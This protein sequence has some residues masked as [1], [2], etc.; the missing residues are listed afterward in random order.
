MSI[1]KVVDLEAAP[2]VSSRVEERVRAARPNCRL[3]VEQIE[4]VELAPPDSDDWQEVQFLHF[5]C[6]DHGTRW[7]EFVGGTTKLSCRI[8]ASACSAAG[9]LVENSRSEL[10]EECD[11]SEDED[12]SLGDGP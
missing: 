11:D 6:E 3:R 2:I 12:D 1:V 8:R 9:S 10:E 5:V 4:K 7:R